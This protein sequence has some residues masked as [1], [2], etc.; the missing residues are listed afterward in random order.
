MTD[1]EQEKIAVFRF[2]VIAP[3]VLGNYIE[4][5]QE[6][7]YKNASARITKDAD[8]NSYVVSPST[9][10]RWYLKY[11]HHGLEGLYPKKRNDRGKSR[12]IKSD[13]FIRI[14]E[15][16]AKFPRIPAT[17][18]YQELIKDGLINKK[19][20]SLS[21]INRLVKSLDMKNN[22]KVQKDMRRYEKEH[23]NEL[24]CGDS[25]VGPYIKINGKKTKT[26]MIALIDDAS[27][28]VVGVKIFENDNFVNLMSV[29]KSAIRKYGKPKYFNFDNGGPYKN[30][31]MSLLAARIG[32]V[33]RYCEP[34]SPESKSKIERW[35]RTCKDHW[36]RVIDWNNFQS[37][38]ELEKD[39]S[40][41]V[42]RYNNTPHSSLGITPV[43]RFF[44]ENE[45]IKRLSD[46]EIK[47]YFY[48]EKKCKVSIDNIITL[49]KH[50]YEVPYI[51]SKQLIKIRFN[52]DLS[53]VFVVDNDGVLTPI[54]L[55]DR[56]ANSKIKREKVKYSEV[57]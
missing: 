28:M 1:K 19:E 54:K 56:I 24:W 27:R 23:I 55:V 11:K 25:S 26:Y 33:I 52:Y 10:E 32:S 45:Y 6:M 20:V 53:E 30:E 41:Y 40:D 49:E 29:I 9:I 31:Q 12:K 51:Y 7:F 34:Y 8:G 50:Q 15:L 43:E 14:E 3:L 13:V 44:Q 2:G 57:D 22:Y 5:S 21:T 16:K 39:L 18:I 35:F 46:K 42:N 37:I 48:L 38:D 17:I 4:D 36:M 47:E